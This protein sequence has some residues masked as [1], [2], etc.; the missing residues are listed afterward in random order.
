MGPLSFTRRKPTMAKQPK[1]AQQIRELADRKGL[2]LNALKDYY[3]FSNNTWMALLAGKRTG[4]RKGTLNRVEALMADINLPSISEIEPVKPAPPVPEP[5]YDGIHFKLESVQLE[6]GIWRDDPTT[7]TREVDFSLIVRLDQF[8]RGKM[9][10]F[11]GVIADAIAARLADE[12]CSGTERVM[13]QH[14]SLCEFGGIGPYA[15]Y[16]K[17]LTVSIKAPRDEMRMDC[18]RHVN[19]VIGPPEEPSLVSKDH[20]AIMKIESTGHMTVVLSSAGFNQLY[21]VIIDHAKVSATVY[22][23]GRYN[24]IRRQDPPKPL[25][26]HQVRKKRK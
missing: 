25:P 22:I 6:P 21:P 4:F 15:T 18:H 14:L 17:G 5:K 11:P 10:P 8:H 16:R 7:E 12:R 23:Q 13:L 20:L 26:A 3:R 9:V 19:F 2:S 1:L 24:A